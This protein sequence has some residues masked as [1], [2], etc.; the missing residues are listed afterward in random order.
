MQRRDFI[1]K[2][3][4]STLGLTFIPSYLAKAQSNDQRK[5]PSKTI[6]LAMIGMG[7]QA[8][9]VNLPGFFAIPKI[10][11]IAVCDVDLNRA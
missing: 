6:N 5:A 3:A 9:N 7:R 2:S 4:A 10:R 8:F 1:A 11:I